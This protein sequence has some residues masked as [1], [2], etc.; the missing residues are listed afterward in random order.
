MNF[1]SLC[2]LSPTVNPSCSLGCRFIGEVEGWISHAQRELD[3]AFVGDTAKLIELGA[4]VA[5]PG[6]SVQGLQGFWASVSLS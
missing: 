2:T 6:G 1:G 5:F 4:I 3:E